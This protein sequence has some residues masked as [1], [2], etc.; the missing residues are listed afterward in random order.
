MRSAGAGRPTR[1]TPAAWVAAALDEIEQAGVDGL[2]VEAVARRLGV[3]KGGFY[4]H[5]AD[6][7]ELLRAALALWEQ[8]FVAELGARLQSIEDPGERLHSLLRHALI[9]LEPTVIVRLMAE[10]DDPDVAATLARA[11][12]ARLAL[13]TRIF[14][15]LDFTPAIARHRALSTY[16]A[17]LG[18]AQLRREDPAVL[19]T[20]AMMRAYLAELE[21][22][23]RSST[24]GRRDNGE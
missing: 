6:R 2:A 4:H 20:P 9:E 10:A 16:S 11:T 24:T 19:G 5:F 15:E 1:T 14:T 3:S 17:Y 8:R 7:R 18:F 13:L 12:A 21:S 23:L 22:M